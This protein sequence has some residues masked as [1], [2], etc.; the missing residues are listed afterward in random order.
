MKGRG[1]TYSKA[2]KLSDIV[3]EVEKTADVDYVDE[4]DWN[5]AD[6]TRSNIT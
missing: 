5:D 3:A 4:V 2:A 6:T 1:P